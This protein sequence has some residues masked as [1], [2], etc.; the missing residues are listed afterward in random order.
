MSERYG[1]ISVYVH[2]EDVDAPGYY[3][4]IKTEPEELVV[5][6]GDMSVEQFEKALG[7]KAKVAAIEA[8]RRLYDNDDPVYGRSNRP[9]PETNSLCGRPSR[10]GPC[11]LRAG[12]NRG[13]ADIPAN[14]VGRGQT[15]T[16][17]PGA[18]L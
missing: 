9:M 7:E 14:H 8:A 17:L 4:D 13:R 16:V 3:V 5:R 2:V 15:V 6:S 1:V 10:V 18:S 12:H 11:L